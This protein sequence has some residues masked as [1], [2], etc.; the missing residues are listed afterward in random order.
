MNELIQS[1]QEKIGLTG[2]QAKDAVNHIIEYIKGKVPASLHEHLDAAAIGETLKAKG[3]E[4]LTQAQTSGGEFLKM[5]EEKIS[6][7]L[8]P[9]ES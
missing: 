9:K 5:A 3:A 8:H 6:T 2:D 1:L 7:F 4:Y